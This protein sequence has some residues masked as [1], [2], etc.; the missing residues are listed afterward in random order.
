[1]TPR[2]AAHRLTASE[3]IDQ[4]AETIR[5]LTERH[6]SGPPQVVVNFTRNAKSETQV[7]VKVTANVDTD[8]RA[9]SA[10]ADTTFRLAVGL[11][12][13]ALRLYPAGEP[14][15]APADKPRKDLTT[16]QAAAI[17]TRRAARREPGRKA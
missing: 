8:H 15:E 4:Q 12:E 1:M 3:F 11:Y 14:A 9:L 13:R 6:T 5:A 10:H 16:R 17:V 2:N 7:D